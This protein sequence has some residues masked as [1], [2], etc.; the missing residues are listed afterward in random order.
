LFEHDLFRKP[1]PTFRDHAKKKTPPGGGK[2]GFPYTRRR[3]GGLEKKPPS[4]RLVEGQEPE[5][6]PAPTIP[7]FIHRPPKDKQYHRSNAHWDRAGG[8]R[9]RCA[10]AA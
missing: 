4:C 6:Q 5:V 2:A 10:C 8:S 9:T 3:V 1:V 7:Q